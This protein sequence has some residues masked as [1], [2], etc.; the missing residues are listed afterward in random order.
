MFYSIGFPLG[1]VFLWGM[2]RQRFFAT[3]HVMFVL[4]FLS[5]MAEALIFTPFPLMILYSGLLV[6]RRST[7]P[8][9]ERDQRPT[10]LPAHA[11][12]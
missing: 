3:K 6:G 11:R 2:Y 10:A 4:L 12:A 7:A 1:L 9:P 8:S 5:L